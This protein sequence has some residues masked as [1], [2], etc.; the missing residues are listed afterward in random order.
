[1]QA[2][3]VTEGSSYPCLDNGRHVMSPIP[4][5]DTPKL[6]QAEHLT[7][8]SAGREKRL[9]AVPPWT[10]VRPLAF[11]DV[12]FKVEDQRGRVCG[13][14]G[15]TDL[16]MNELPQTDGGSAFELSDSGLADKLAR[17]RAGESV[18]VGPTY[19]VD[20]ELKR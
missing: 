6:H 18:R 17:R 12:A 8:L 10:D 4:R 7:L 5:W 16:F 11:S 9:Y 13:R 15:A 20:G 14:T 3:R 19:Y 2:G 1:M